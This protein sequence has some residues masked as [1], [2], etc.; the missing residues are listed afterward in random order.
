MMIRVAYLS[1]IVG[2]DTAH[3]SLLSWKL[4]KESI[5]LVTRARL[6][7]DCKHC[8][9]ASVPITHF[10]PSSMCNAC[11]VSNFAFPTDILLQDQVIISQHIL[12]GWRVGKLASEQT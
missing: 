3:L 2:D 7:L 11:Y 4:N 6:N 9:S 5:S 1:G 10:I 8:R 12:W